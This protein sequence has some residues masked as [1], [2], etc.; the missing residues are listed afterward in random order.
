MKLLIH[1]KKSRL[2]FIHLTF[3]V[4]PLL[5]KLS[6]FHPTYLL[7]YHVAIPSKREEKNWQD[8][9]LSI[10]SLQVFIDLTLSF[11][12]CEPFVGGP[13]GMFCGTVTEIE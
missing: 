2:L 1:S 12:T 6:T 9:Y 7:A 3:I 8:S 13:E 5:S 10:S 11:I 4:F